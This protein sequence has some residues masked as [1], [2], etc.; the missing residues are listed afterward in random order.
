MKRKR[1]SLL[2]LVF[3]PIIL[4]T[5]VYFSLG[6]HLSLVA[7]ISYVVL[8]IF[9]LPNG[10]FISTNSDYHTKKANP[11]YQ[12]EKSDISSLTTKNLSN[13]IIL[14]LVCQHFFEQKL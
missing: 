5:I 4:G 14:F 11:N 12:V 2:L 6:I 10:S 9:N 13:L 8:F 7:G 1:I 3:A